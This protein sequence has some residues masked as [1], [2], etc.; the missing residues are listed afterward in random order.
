[1]KAAR[2]TGITVALLTGFL[3]AGTPSTFAGF[4]WH[5]AAD[6]P[7][8]GAL[9]DTT[10]SAEESSY[11]ATR[12]TGDSPMHEFLVSVL[13]DVHR[14][15][16]KQWSAYGYPIPD[17]AFRF[18]APGEQVPITVECTRD[19]TGLS[20]DATAQ[21]CA[22]DDGIVISQAIADLIGRGEV[23]VNDDHIDRY[24]PG[25]FSVAYVVAHEYAHNLQAELGLIGTS[26]NGRARRYPV[27]TE[28][29]HADCWSGVWARSASDRRILDPGD[30]GEAIQ[31]T[32]DFGDYE[33]WAH[34][35]HGTPAQRADAFLAGLAG[36]APTVCDGYLQTD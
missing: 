35:H 31:T 27:H 14:Y 16:S 22:I 7:R 23:E 36:G 1:M 21:Y 12:G 11:F 26:A 9:P 6:R 28:E 20:N 5:A 33:V 25:D 4:G 34:D 2:R 3:L 32:M 29:L 18:P 13:N 17:V 10:I 8:V 19:G 15:W 24:R 30:I